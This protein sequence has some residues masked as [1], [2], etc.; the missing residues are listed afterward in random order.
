MAEIFY[1][2]KTEN[3]SR[4][5][6]VKVE[7]RK[8]RSRVEYSNQVV[9]PQNLFKYYKCNKNNLKVLQESKIWASNL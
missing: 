5:H 9:V 2:S 1:P 3:E 4:K 8:I 7:G 6:F